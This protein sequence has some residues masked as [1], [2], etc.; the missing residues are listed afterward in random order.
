MVNLPVDMDHSAANL[1]D[2]THHV[3]ND[4]SPAKIYVTH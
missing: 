3:V 2:A 1:V 4:T